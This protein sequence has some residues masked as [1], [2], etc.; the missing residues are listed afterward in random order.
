MKLELTF[1]IIKPHITSVPFRLQDIRNRILSNGF[2]IIK[3][4]K[5]TLNTSQAHE[6]YNEHK[7]KFFFN[8]L[9]TFMCS[10][11]CYF[12]ILAR[13]NAI[14]VWRTMMGPTKVFKTIFTHPDS[15]RGVHGLSDTRNATHGSDS[16]QSFEKEAKIFFPD[17]NSREWYAKEEIKFIE[18]NSLFDKDKFEHVTLKEQM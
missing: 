10:G 9:V 17:F 15:I 11:P 5:E 6:F 4:K 14:E 2:Y 16:K 12:H 13:E 3:T 8:R 1:A 7:G 18:G